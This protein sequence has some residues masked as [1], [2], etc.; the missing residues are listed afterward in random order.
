M[1]DI[2]S[3]NLVKEWT[4]PHNY[5]QIA[6]S[7]LVAIGY[8]TVS[9]HAMEEEWQVIQSI[10]TKGVSCMS[11]SPDGRKIACGTGDICVYDVSSGTLVLGPL[12]G[13][14]DDIL[15]IL[16]SS[17]GSRIFSGSFDKTIHCWDSVTAEPIRH[18]WACHTDRITSLSF[19]PDGSI[20]AS[21][22]DD[23]TI[24]FWDTAT[25]SPIGQPLQHQCRLL[26]VCFSPS[27]EFVASVGLGRMLY[28]WQTPWSDTIES[29]VNEIRCSETLHSHLSFPIL[30][31]THSALLDASIRPS[32]Q[33]PSLSRAPYF[34]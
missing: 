1:W 7:P 8:S 19:F 26:A 6:L 24:R 33:A 17:D 15:S 25:G 2:E 11:F 30:S 5:P 12:T 29:R 22:S 31:Q 21:A 18:P 32:T 14:Q 13:H 23:Q 28:W 34:K 10:E 3:H 4:H 9:I 16:W 20:L 27:G